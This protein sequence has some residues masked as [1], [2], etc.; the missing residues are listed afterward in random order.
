M[1]TI[2]EPLASIQARIDELQ[3]TIAEKEAQIK[4]RAR[5]LKTDIEAE[6]S[7]VKL[8]KKYPFPA[9]GIMFV[10]GLL[11]GRALRGSSSQASTLAVQKDCSSVEYLP[12][13]QKSAMSTIGLEA[14]RSAKDLGF[15]CLQ[16]YIDKKIT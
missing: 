3:N 6:L 12:T 8:V 2:N 9:T 10:T 5:K 7:P 15:A 1:T 13:S 16:R 4:A 14:L 11:I